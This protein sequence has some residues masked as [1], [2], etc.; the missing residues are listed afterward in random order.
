MTLPVNHVN[1]LVKN[2][3]IFPHRV[4]DNNMAYG[5]LYDKEHL[6]EYA[7]FVKYDIHINL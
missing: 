1:D 7:N 2:L 3:P 4:H 5:H 6:V